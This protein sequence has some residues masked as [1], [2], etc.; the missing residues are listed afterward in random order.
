MTETHRANAAY[1]GETVSRIEDTDLPP[2]FGLAG[3]QRLLSRE[4]GAPGRGNQ[5]GQQKRR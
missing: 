3:G 4:E 1:L 2:P 5:R